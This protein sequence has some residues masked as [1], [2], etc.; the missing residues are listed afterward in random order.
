MAETAAS[1]LGG[2][3]MQGTNAGAHV[4]PPEHA[5]TVTPQR[6]RSPRT[7]AEAAAD[8]AI[9][10][11]GLVGEDA[12]IQ[13]ARPDAADRLRV[14]W[15]DGAPATPHIDRARLRRT[16]YLQHRERL[17]RTGGDRAIALVPL[18]TASAS[19]GTLE[20]DA[21][22]DRLD[23]AWDAISL[24]GG[25]LAATIQATNEFARL[26]NEVRTLEAASLLGRR[27]A[28]ASTTG[29]GVE[30]AVRFLGS[31]FRVPAAG[32][33]R[34]PDGSLNLVAT[35]RVGVRARATL[36]TATAD[37]D[38][39]AS[40]AVADDELR[41]VLA[42]AMRARD[43]VTFDAGPALLM[44]VRREDDPSASTIDEI[45]ALFGEMLRLGA[46]NAAAVAR[47]RQLDMGLAWTAHELKGPLMGV[48]AALEA[49]DR[50]VEDP[51]HRA[52]MQ[53]SVRELDQLVG[54]TEAL[55][56][57]A[58]GTRSITREPQDL[59]ALVRDAADS[60]VRETGID[61]VVTQAP[62]DAVVAV[63]RAHVRTAVSNLLRNA[64]THAD[65]GTHVEVSVVE[66]GEHT[67]LR[68]TDRGPEIAEEDRVA[69]FDPFVRGEHA[70]RARDGHGLGLF[71]TRRVVEAHGGSVWVES[72][73]RRTTF[74][75]ALPAEE[76]GERRFAS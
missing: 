38:R 6:V 3:T 23:A 58:A 54:T 1:D 63:D 56:T 5:R 32:W 74:A 31:R 50:R 65:P 15:R 33:T 66:D 43:A 71:I 64:A 39:G 52:M 2:G 61:T 16:T 9:K 51:Q 40:E 17:V 28:Y 27:L 35:S 8:L 11:R 41:R 46:A 67:V 25:H 34:S 13:I 42:G 44:I 55:L 29:A 4:A 48:R 75:I 69:I 26:R 30:T 37:T 21:E 70:G 22:T 49:M 57:W 24:L 7:L 73:G 72:A 62:R 36:T 76:R 20:I 59:V 68:V 53:S 12:T 10:V 45:G 14:V 47:R 60:N 19:L 18:A